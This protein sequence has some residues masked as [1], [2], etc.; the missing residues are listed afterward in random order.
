MHKMIGVL[1]RTESAKTQQ[2][3]IDQ[4]ESYADDIIECREWYD[5]H[6][7]YADTRE[8]YDEAEILK[9]DT[10]QGAEKI[11]T[12]RESWQK[13][14][15]DIIRKARETFE[16]YTDTQIMNGNGDRYSIGRIATLSESPL[17]GENF[18]HV[19]FSRDFDG[20]ESSWIVFLDFHY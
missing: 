15:L 20:M 13:E 3:A 10:R 8:F 2:E 16:K 19:E 14:Q 6:Q 4:A 1:V 9:T 7:S 11:K 17:V 12:L 18:G 5:Y